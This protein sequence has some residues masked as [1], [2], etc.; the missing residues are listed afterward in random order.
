MTYRC[1]HALAVDDIEDDQGIIMLNIPR[2]SKD[3]MK[4]VKLSEFSG[5]IFEHYD[6]LKKP[7]PPQN[8]E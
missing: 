3:E 1:T 4:N 8:R 5:V 2:L 6:G 7:I